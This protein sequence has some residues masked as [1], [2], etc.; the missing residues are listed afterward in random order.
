LG[1]ALTTITMDDLLCR[2]SLDGLVAHLG[3]PAVRADLRETGLRRALLLSACQAARAAGAVQLS[4]EAWGDTDNERREDEALGLVTDSF[5]QIY[6]LVSRRSPEGQL[7]Q[8]LG[9]GA[10][11]TTVKEQTP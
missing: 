3:T 9:A 10:L 7:N 6:T 8:P 11:T 5:T 4:L 1:E 2:V